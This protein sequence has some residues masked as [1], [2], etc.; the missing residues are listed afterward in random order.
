MIIT[1]ILDNQKT[2]RW[3]A[4]FYIKYL[5]LLLC[6]H[7]I[8]WRTRKLLPL[9]FYFFLL[10]SIRKKETHYERYLLLRHDFLN[11]N[12]ESLLYPPTWLSEMNRS[13]HISTRSVVSSTSSHAGGLQGR[14]TN[15]AVCFLMENGGC[16]ELWFQ[17]AIMEHIFWL[18]FTMGIKYPT[19]KYS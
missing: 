16:G 1:Y 9:S 13:K 14:R 2:P 3:D 12:A 8:K 4:I 10:F 5:N 19:Q 7:L 17:S 18:H 15:C 11:S 6:S